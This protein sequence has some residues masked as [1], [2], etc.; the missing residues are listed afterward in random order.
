MRKKIE[1]LRVVIPVITTQVMMPPLNLAELN[2]SVAKANG[3]KIDLDKMLIFT[4][5]NKI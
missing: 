1:S 2:R 5:I 4:P 3:K